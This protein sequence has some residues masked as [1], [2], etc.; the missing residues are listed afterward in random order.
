MEQSLRRASSL[1]TYRRWAR[2]YLALL[3]ALCVLPLGALAA[4]VDV[5]TA[6]QSALEGVKGLGPAMSA[7]I[8][9]ERGKGRF[10][11]WPDLATRVSGLG[12]KNTA[13]LSRNGLVIDGKS[14]PDAAPTSNDAKQKVD[15]DARKA[16]GKGPRGKSE[17]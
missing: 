12:D 9:A 16:P 8:I 13:N 15:A 6:D 2:R 10:R 3:F 1:R 14:K 5:N 4:N 17:G 7:R 11:D